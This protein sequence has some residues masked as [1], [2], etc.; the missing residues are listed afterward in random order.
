[1]KGCTHVNYTIDIIVFINTL[2]SVILYFNALLFKCVIQRVASNKSV[3]GS[4]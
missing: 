3:K 4:H 2:L 1:M